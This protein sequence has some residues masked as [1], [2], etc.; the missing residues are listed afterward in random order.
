MKYVNICID[1]EQ[2]NITFNMNQ[3]NIQS[4]VYIPDISEICREYRI[5]W[6]YEKYTGIMNNKK[7]TTY[8]HQFITINK[9][10]FPRQISFNIKIVIYHKI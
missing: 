9:T 2:T 7:S 8:T 10:L 5:N 6:M 3:Q 1:I 4:T